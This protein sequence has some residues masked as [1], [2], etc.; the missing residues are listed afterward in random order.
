[1]PMGKDLASTVQVQLYNL[2]WD[3]FRVHMG[4]IKCLWH[5]VIVGCLAGTPKIA[6]LYCAF[7]LFKYYFKTVQEMQLQEFISARSFPVGIHFAQIV[8]A[9]SQM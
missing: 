7:S 5:I 4:S 1:M 9:S 8:I 6:G 3:L 2:M